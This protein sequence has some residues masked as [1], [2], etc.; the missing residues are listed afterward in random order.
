M[1]RGASDLFNIFKF[2]NF[3]QVF[4]PKLNLCPGQGLVGALYLMTNE[5]RGNFLL[6]IGIYH[7][8]VSASLG[9]HR[10]P[11]LAHSTSGLGAIARG[12]ST[13]AGG[14]GIDALASQN[15]ILVSEHL[16]FAVNAGSDSVSLF[17][18]NP[19]NPVELSLVSTFPS[20]GH[21]PVALAYSKLR[22][23]LCVAN[24]GVQNSVQCF[25]Q[26]FFENYTFV[27][28]RDFQCDFVQ[29]CDF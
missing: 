5:P 27:T 7:D 16:L 22:E 29:N 9:A 2:N 11:T 23:M 1:E 14:S 3:N 24:G 6:S 28:F 4:N 19:V 13:R 15:S 12:A 18:I 17:Q 21:F 26:G 10:S 8:G 20:G 25:R